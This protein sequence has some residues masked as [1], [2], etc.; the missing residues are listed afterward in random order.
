MLINGTVHLHMSLNKMSFPAL[1]CV[2]GFCQSPQ[3]NG[4]LSS[5]QLTFISPAVTP[6]DVCISR[7]AIMHDRPITAIRLYILPVAHRGAGVTVWNTVSLNEEELWFANQNGAS[8]SSEEMSDAVD[9]LT[10]AVR[11]CTQ[12]MAGCT[13]ADDAA[14]KAVP[15]VVLS[16]T[17]NPSESWENLISAQPLVEDHFEMES[18]KSLF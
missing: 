2:Q 10:A 17:K 14:D 8:L 4:L 11:V 12:E 18:I 7:D 5:L 3:V 9:G 16:F 13:T 6:E 1:G 15:W